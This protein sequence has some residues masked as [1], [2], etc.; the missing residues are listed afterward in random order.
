LAYIP[1]EDATMKWRYGEIVRAIM[2]AWLVLSAALLHSGT[3]ESTSNNPLAGRWD[4]TLKTPKGDLPSWLEVSFP[5]GVPTALFVG[6]MDHAVPPKGLSIKGSEFQ[7][8]SPKGEEGFPEDM[9]FEGKLVG[10]N[11]VGTVSGSAGARWTLTGVRAPLLDAKGTPQWGPPI[12]LFNGVDLSG[13]TLRDPGKPDSWKVK[14]GEL[15]AAGRGSDLVTIAK[16][17]DFKLHVEFKNGKS[18][19]SGVYL[20]GRY[21]LQIET[22]E[23]AQSGEFHTASIYGFLAPNPEQ[24]RVP[25]VWQTFDITLIGRRL[26]VLQ[27]GITV[28]DNREIPGITGGALD[29]NEALRG[30]IYLQGSEDGPVAFR[31]IVIRPAKD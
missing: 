3:Q 2:L 28:I 14:H 27:D 30:P 15:I 8:L 24:P 6:A 10:G 17:D 31:N 16:F 11:L 20:R 19:N 1:T 5:G 18:T 4:L 26:T 9:V 12:E 13:W 22:D 7:F 29:S 23:A 25:E 21:E